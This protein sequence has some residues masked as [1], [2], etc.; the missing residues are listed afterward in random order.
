MQ[1]ILFSL[2]RVCLVVVIEN[3]EPS[4]YCVFAATVTTI[5]KQT[6]DNVMMPKESEI[7]F[8]YL[9]KCDYWSDFCRLCLLAANSQWMCCPT[10]STHTFYN[11]HIHT[12]CMANVFIYVCLRF[13]LWSMIITFSELSHESCCVSTF[14]ASFTPLLRIRNI[15][16]ID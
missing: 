11:T 13:K 3:T 4:H 9:L 15:S 6:T 8:L 12:P 14:H 5:P 2:C 1:S 10:D 16:V 7:S